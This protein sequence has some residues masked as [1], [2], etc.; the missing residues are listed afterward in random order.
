MGVNDQGI[1]HGIDAALPLMLARSEGHIPRIGSVAG[2]CRWPPNAA[3]GSSKAALIDLAEAHSKDLAQH[4]VAIIDPRYVATSPAFRIG[5]ED[6]ARRIF[7]GLEKAQIRG[8]LSLAA[9]GAEEVPGMPY[10]LFLACARRVRSPPRS[11]LE[12]P[13]A[14]SAGYRQAN[15]GCSRSATRVVRPASSSRNW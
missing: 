1:V 15:T 8:C 4:G 14:T 2:Y 11:G 5:A 13:S 9:G 3:F 6:A 12:L 7:H 10:P